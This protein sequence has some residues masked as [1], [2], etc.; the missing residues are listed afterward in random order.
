MKFYRTMGKLFSVVTL[1]LGLFLVMSSSAQA[2]EL[3]FVNFSFSEYA[4]FNKAVMEA[5]TAVNPSEPLIEIQPFCMTGGVATWRIN[6]TASVNVFT[7]A[8]GQ[9]QAGWLPV[10]TVV[11]RSSGFAD[12]GGRRCIVGS[13]NGI[14]VVGWVA[15][16]RL[17][18]VN[19][20]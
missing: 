19:V 5:E 6:G 11:T 20:C 10:G 13:R 14:G 16:S 12:Q 9:V 7:T 15:I 3:E 17:T 8:T 4:E 2:S 18:A 1:A